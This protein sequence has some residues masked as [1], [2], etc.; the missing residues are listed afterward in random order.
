MTSA[1]SVRKQ[2]RLAARD[3]Q[4]SAGGKRRAPLVKAVLLLL[5]VALI[6]GL[7]LG[8]RAWFADPLARG[9]AALA[10]GNF[11][12]ARVD[13]MTAV[14][15]QPNDV[16]LRLDLAHAYNSLRRGVEA[17]R[18]LQRAAELGAS[19]A[20]IGASLA[21]A[22][23]LQG[24]P[25]NALDT[26]AAGY[27]RRDA[28]RAMRIA[29]EAH[30]R[31]GAF[32]R[33]RFAFSESVRLAPDSVEN[34]VAVARY[35][36]AEQ[37][38]LGADEAATQAW[39]RAP[40]SAAA[41][42]IKAD[43]VRTREGPVAAIPWYEAAVAR[44]PDNVPVMLEWAASLGDAGHYRD[45]LK[46][47]RRAA[48]LEPGNGRALFQM[49]MVAARAGDWPLARTLLGRIGGAD[50]D[51]PAVLQ[52]RAAVELA[53]DTPSAAERFAARLI[54]LQPDN[55]T[56]RR[57]LALAQARGD[58]PRGAM[59]TL[60]PVTTRPDADSWSLL[61]LSNSFAGMGWQTDAAQPL[62]R[63]SNL[64][65]GDPP[66]LP[67]AADGGD[68]LNPGVAIPTIRARLAR[69][70]PSGAL[71][72]ARRLADANPG[73]AQA[74][75]L[76]GDALMQLGDARAAALEFRRASA[77]RYDEPVM[78]RLFHALVTMG[79]RDAAAEALRQYQM[80]WPENVAA[81]RIAAAFAAEQG[82]WSVTVAQLRAALART[83]PNDALLL[84]Q[85]ARSELEL[86]DAEA[87]L[88]YAR[89][90]YQRLPGNA[91]VSGLYG[92]S[93][94]RTGGSQ[95]DAADLLIKAVSLAPDD[96]LLRAW[97]A[98]VV[99]NRP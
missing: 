42:A 74:R 21:E 28:A 24:R 31:L 56:G 82:Q 68:S 52:A 47:L 6:A 54:E 23:L 11:R 99:A 73:V 84:A 89:R 69:G 60:D 98:E 90:A 48:E 49:G 88:V 63:A 15:A 43:V 46:P 44:D 76:V 58:N 81:M 14:A 34:W 1:P 70:D 92:V 18:Q 50:A 17:E 86:G 71:S 61:L 32:D 5:V 26:L 20:V 37:D 57:L 95:V 51:Q 78:L 27:L 80:R 3:A 91:T 83:G 77:L 2:R 96:A 65:R 79:D 7:A 12:A 93:L 85:L 55:G 38:M 59:M 8:A 40:R 94:G 41:L 13:L 39:R 72:L 25:Q 64:R 30:Y 87:A 75:L 29:G 97:L 9:R 22:Q 4:R 35:R 53:L 16:S 67:A 45:M 33:A 66:P 10:E 36:L 19:P 62:D